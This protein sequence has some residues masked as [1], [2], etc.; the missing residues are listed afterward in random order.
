LA[1]SLATGSADNGALRSYGVSVAGH[2]VLILLIFFLP[3]GKKRVFVE[4]IPRSVKLVATLDTDAPKPR[5]T[6]AVRSRP[7]PQRRPRVVAPAPAPTTLESKVAIPVEDAPP[8][9]KRRAR[10]PDPVSLKDR[11][12]RRL[13]EVAPETAD[14]EAPALSTLDI[15]KVAPLDTSRKV[16]T[17]SLPPTDQVSTLSDF[18]FG[19]YVALVKDKVFSVWRPPSSFAIGGRQLTA[20]ATFRIVRNGR[21]EGLR[22]T[23]GSGH[24]LYDQ[25]VMAAMTGIGSLP[26]LPEQYKEESLDVVI[27]FNSQNR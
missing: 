27:R 14:T 7:K 3:F 23:D 16:T 20:V 26:P 6:P 13:S 9:L 24:R 19:W 10:A 15:P 22:I 12:S 5:P 2:T 21:I 8:L 17:A 1:L 25:S 11:M 4:S 18:P